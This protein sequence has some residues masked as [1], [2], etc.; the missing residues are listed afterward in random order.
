MQE[1]GARVTL[2]LTALAGGN[3]H[4]QKAREDLR[5]HTPMVVPERRRHMSFRRDG[6]DRCKKG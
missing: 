6:G 4:D 1:S 3:S 2:V 5:P